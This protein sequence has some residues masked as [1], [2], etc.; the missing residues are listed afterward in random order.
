MTVLFKFSNR[1][2]FGKVVW[3][4]IG[5]RRNNIYHCYSNKYNKTI[6]YSIFT[7]RFKQKVAEVI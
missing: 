1:T 7:N 3:I 4:F 2:A 6:E 5:G